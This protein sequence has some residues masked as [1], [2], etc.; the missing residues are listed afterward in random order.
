[1][2]INSEYIVTRK[3]KIPAWMNN[4][5][6]Q[7]YN[8]I[9]FFIP[10]LC[11]IFICFSSL[12]NGQADNVEDDDLQ[13]HYKYLSL[14]EKVCTLIWMR[15]FYYGWHWKATT[16][17]LCCHLIVTCALRLQRQNVMKQR[18]IDVVSSKKQV[19]TAI[20]SVINHCK[21]FWLKILL[22]PL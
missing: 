11:Q 21:V 16:R 12:Q 8:W 5:M 18:K 19:R 3:I 13:P 4:W 2:S 6:I 10:D 9:G 17:I 22:V 7:W 1:M 14:V 15:A 20:F